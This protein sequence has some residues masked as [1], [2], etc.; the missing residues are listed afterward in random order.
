MTLLSGTIRE[1]E[2]PM[3]AVGCVGGREGIL[4]RVFHSHKIAGGEVV[5][6]KQRRPHVGALHSI[7]HGTA[8]PTETIPSD[9]VPCWTNGGL[10]MPP[11]SRMRAACR[12]RRAGGRTSPTRRCAT[13]ASQSAR[14][15]AWTYPHNRRGLCSKRYDRSG[16]NLGL[17]G[18]DHRACVDPCVGTRH[19][20]HHAAWGTEARAI[21]RTCPEGE[22]HGQNADIGAARSES[23]RESLR[24]IARES[25]QTNKPPNPK[26]SSIDKRMHERVDQKSIKSRSGERRTCS[27]RCASDRRHAS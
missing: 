15:T 14:H 18:G 24:K 13:P 19:I 12:G 17:G 3:L 27:H 16:T 1:Y 10:G 6:T 26:R 7:L 11:E 20:E 2:W 4:E 9:T 22:V 21:W 5:E 8:I 25:L 23:R